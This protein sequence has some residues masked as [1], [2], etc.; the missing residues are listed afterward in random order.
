M[1]HDVEPEQLTL[2]PPPAQVTLHVL[3]PPQFTFVPEPTS[4]LHVLVP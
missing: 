3:F 2:H 1:L 4:T